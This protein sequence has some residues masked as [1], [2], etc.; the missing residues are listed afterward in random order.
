MLIGLCYDGME[1]DVYEVTIYDSRVKHV[2]ERS[3]LSMAECIWFMIH[4]YVSITVHIF[5]KL[6]WLICQQ[7]VS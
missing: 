1:Q 5:A 4:D 6:C 7:F 3:I 2:M